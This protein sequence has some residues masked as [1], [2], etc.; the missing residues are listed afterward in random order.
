M[1]SAMSSNRFRNELRGRG[2]ESTGSAM[3]GNG[4]RNELRGG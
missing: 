2:E 4:F 3:S 1:S